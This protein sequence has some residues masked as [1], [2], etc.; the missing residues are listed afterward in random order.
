[1]PDAGAVDGTRDEGPGAGPDEGLGA[2]TIV[3]LAAMALGIFAVAN[4]FTALSVAVVEI[5]NDLDTTLNRAQ[6]VINAYTV[7]FGV[8][9]V[10]GGR[11]ADMF[12]RRRLFIIG[13]AIFAGFSLLGGLAPNIELLI[14]SRAIMGIGG[15]FMWPSV[16]GMTYAILP[17]DKAGLAGGLVIG[18]AGLGNATGPILSGALTDALSWRWVFFVNVPV[19]AVA[20]FATWRFVHTDEVAERERIDAAGIVSL[21]M[22]IVLVLV[23]LDIGSTRGFDDALAIAPLVVGV[24][25]LPAFVAIERRVGHAALVPARVMNNRTFVGALASVCLL[26]LTF[27]G[28]VV[29]V[30][31]FLQNEL[32][33]SALEA[34]AG[35]LP[36]MLTFGAVSFGAGPLYGLIGARP[37]LVSGAFAMVAGAAL[38]AWRIGSD[39]ADLVPGLVVLGI[40]IGLFFSAL[41]TAAVTAVDDADASLA[42][43]IIYMGNVAGGSIGIGLNTA[44]V[45]S[46]SS[47]VDGITVAFAVNAV[48]GTLGTIVVLTT[49]HGD[50][51]TWSPLHRLHHHAHP[52]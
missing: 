35:L 14:A 22:S 51:G 12:G 46:N 23:G 5:E 49:V 18:V 50:P 30:P 2:G 37:V 16:L 21:S 52:A 44:I 17:E 42:G 26:A 20:V 6:W 43:G 15:A 3:A 47:F 19:A 28:A 40:G 1:M 11:L 13:A 38:L 25:L 39:Y 31:Q 8:L 36:L 9:I 10:T 48:L 29:Y 41:T 7:V 27:F 4:D 45:L 24:L 34:G 33:W 32:D